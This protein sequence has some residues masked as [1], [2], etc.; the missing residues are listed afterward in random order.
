MLDVV[1]IGR[2]SV[3]LYGQQIGGR[4]E[5]MATFAKAVGGCPANIAIGCARLGL[6]ASLITRVGDE[7]MGRFIREQLLREGVDVTGVVTDTKRLTALALL[8]VENERDF[9]LIF[10]REN[11]ADMALCEA[12][13][14][15]DFIGSAKAIVLTG[16]HLSAENTRAALKKA[17][18]LAKAA[19]VRIVL[20]IDYRPNLWGLAGHGEGSARFI[21]S[22]TVTAMLADLLP[23]CDLIV[24]TEEEFHIAGG[25]AETLTALR[26][27]RGCTGATLV[28][29][30]GPIGC[31]IFP[32]AIPGDLEAGLQG[33]G[34]SVE[35]YNVLG[36]GDAF[37]AGL[38]RGWLRDEPLEVAAR[39]A[40]ACGAI[41]VSRLLCSPEYAT[42]PELQH[43]LSC[44]I[45]APRLREDKALNHIHRTTTRRTG[46]PE[47][48]ALAIDHRKHLT[49]LCQA[50]GADP[51]MLERFKMLAIEAAARAAN[52]EPGFG[53]L[54]D[55]RFGRA[56]LFKAEQYGLWIA[57]PVE[58]PG[59]VPLRFECG[60]DLGAHLIEW[61]ASHVAKAL[62]F[63][64]PDDAPE[65][66]GAQDQAL[67]HLQ[68][69]AL[70]LGREFLIEI[71][72]G[73]SAPL[74]EDTVARVVDHLY[75]LGIKPDW[76]KLEPQA[77]PT[78]WERIDAVIAR[79]DP[80]CRGVVILGLE[81][82][83]AALAAAF[84]ASAGSPAVK[85]FAVGRTIF[86]HAAEKW[87]RREIG[88]ET[89][90]ADMAGRFR[91]FVAL[92]RGRRQ[93][94]AGR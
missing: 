10:Y 81:A 19:G 79:H 91:S 2:S 30:R 58:A 94:Q 5:D 85:G 50:L 42:W 37:M 34:F 9:P 77:S 62:C 33:P 20:D 29:K 44:D 74:A 72:A 68:E 89:A 12:D 69:A 84:R 43:F 65:L 76:W 22:E 70:K 4:L 92:W 59:S 14:E 60:H 46:Q 6:R 28:C 82:D 7:A 71:I 47:L 75:G 87:L 88:D 80:A 61:P 56:A 32:E 35:V 1:T 78:A 55:D 11:C 39:W 40:N 51:R 23:A 63:Y 86:S 45:P 18:R 41:A 54:C 25:A 16:T 31:V 64:H 27:V 66:R 8:G 24:G 13:I 93:T 67:L 26:N 48:L 90:I 83:E 38:L 17:A 52:G 3:D 73:K 53:V 36:A 15:A 57:R 49:D 21:G